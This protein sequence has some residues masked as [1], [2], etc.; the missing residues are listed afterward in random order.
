M[1]FDRRIPSRVLAVI[2]T[3]ALKAGISA[4]QPVAVNQ[5]RD[6]TLLPAADGARLEMTVRDPIQPRLQILAHPPRL[7]IDLPATSS[8]MPADRIATGKF[9]VTALRIGTNGAVPPDTRVVVDLDHECAYDLQGGRSGKLSILLHTAQLPPTRAA[10][11][12]NVK[13]ASPPIP[14]L[15]RAALRSGSQSALAKAPST[16]APPQSATRD[17]KPVPDANAPSKASPPTNPKYTGEPISVN[18]KDVD[19]RDFFRL[20]HEISGLNVVLDPNVKGT[21]TLVLDDVPWDQALEIVLKNNNLARQLDGNVLRVATLETLR[22]EADSRREQQNALYETAQ[23]LIV[24]TQKVSLSRSIHHNRDHP[25]I[26]AYDSLKA[27]LIDGEAALSTGTARSH[28]A[29]ICYRADKRVA[30]PCGGNLRCE[31]GRGDRNA[32]SRECAVLWR[33][34]QR[35]RRDNLHA[36]LS[37]GLRD[38]VDGQA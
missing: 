30:A 34:L 19:L 38:E 16:P 11:V 26:G 23:D 5:L 24:L 17:A 20:V 21:L 35:L 3:F 22:K 33:L 12:A 25:R 36:G 4:A 10:D 6:L 7:V 31:I 32:G 1:R 15:L 29:V 14:S 9:G 28:H 37:G 27:D 18:L 13:P 2:W 8:S